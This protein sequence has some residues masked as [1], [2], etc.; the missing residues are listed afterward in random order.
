MTR[1]HK[2][3]AESAHL[4]RVAAAGCA[5]CYFRLGRGFVPCQIHHLGEG[6]SRTTDFATVGLC[7]EHHDPI[8]KGTGFHGMGA[9][10]FCKLFR[11][12]WEREEGLLVLENELLS[13]V[14]LRDNA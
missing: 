10:R 6:S 13:I 8:K 11:I 3:R 1:K 4:E 5:I 12:P 2:T 14:A 7:F 9:E